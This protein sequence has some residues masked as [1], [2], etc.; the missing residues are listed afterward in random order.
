MPSL[1]PALARYEHALER[2]HNDPGELLAVLLARDAVA[3]AVAEQGSL[4]VEQARHLA[5]LDK[6]L[7]QQARQHALSDLPSWRDSF[8]PPD[9]AWW[10]HFDTP[11]GPE[12]RSDVPWIVL[13][14]VLVTLTIPLALEIIRRLWDGAPD[15]I[16]L[17]GTLLTVLL[18]GGPLTRRGQEFARWVLCR[19][20]LVKP[21]QQAEVM[22][23][24]AALVFGVVLLLRLVAVPM[25]A[26]AYN[27]WGLN[28]LD[29][30]DITAARQ[31]FQRSTALNPDAA[32][33]YI[34]LGDAYAEIGLHDEA[35]LWYQQ[36]LERDA[37]FRP[38]YA[39]LGYQYNLQGEHATAQ[40][41]LLA[42]LALDPVADDEE[43]VEAT[44]Y[45]LL[46]NL[47]WTYVA[48]DEYER[49]LE[50]LEEA[51]R[52]EPQNQGAL[53]H[54]YLAQVYEERGDTE[55]ACHQWHETLRYV[56]NE[57]WQDKQWH[58]QATQRIQELERCAP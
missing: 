19:L 16:S 52:L 53:P 46:S 37:N 38:I 56:D 8:T 58:Q 47:G 2:L 10:W 5:A 44:D 4:S 26:V 35:V 17:V 25:L 31:H 30:G 40:Q 11:V 43:L 36:A 21:G 3:M 50:A 9:T 18:T 49:A 20:P 33:P 12:A 14:S 27:T 7:H 29:A 24:T 41:I 13:A 55:E 54:Y 48:Q 42:G 23:G 1:G 34:H 45:A 28:A 22:A 51:V 6:K 39:R 15:T 32:V 57:I